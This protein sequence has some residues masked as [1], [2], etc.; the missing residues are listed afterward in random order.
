MTSSY[1]NFFISQQVNENAPHFIYEI[2]IIAYDIIDINVVHCKSM[3][4]HRN[5]KSLNGVYNTTNTAI[6]LSHLTVQLSK[7]R[8]K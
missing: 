4:F 6:Y 3:R 1:Y 2:K 7:V 5:K 8:R